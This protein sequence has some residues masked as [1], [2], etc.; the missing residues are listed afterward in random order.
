MLL[1]QSIT[2][3]IS[4][5]FYMTQTDF[6]KKDAELAFVLSSLSSNVKH[7]ADSGLILIRTNHL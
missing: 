3:D 1:S 7:N 5:L 6:C 2:V 4:Q